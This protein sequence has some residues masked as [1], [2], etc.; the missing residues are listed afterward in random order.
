MWKN[1][2]NREVFINEFRK[3]IGNRHFLYES[4]E[5]VEIDLP[6]QPFKPSVHNKPK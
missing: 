1:S 3:K 5:W 6:I 4:G 2:K